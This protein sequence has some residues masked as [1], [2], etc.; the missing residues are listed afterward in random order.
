MYRSIQIMKYR[1]I[2]LFLVVALAGCKSFDKRAI[3]RGY[4]KPDSSNNS[5]TTTIVDSTFN[6]TYVI[7]G[8]SI[9]EAMRIE[10]DSLGQAYIAEIAQ[11]K[12]D[13][14]ELQQ[15]LKNNIL[16]VK[17]VYKDREVKVPWRIRSVKQKE[18]GVKY[19]TV[20]KTPK[21]WKFMG[22]VG[23]ISIV[24]LVLYLVLRN[25]MKIIKKAIL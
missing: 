23:I 14:F 13:V 16:N 17:V 22:W 18:Q 5:T 6:Y 15:S 21:F 7:E 19:V 2:L 9:M 3:E 1:I 4:I 20:Y 8:D 12:G 10:C 11:Y 25:Y 24:L